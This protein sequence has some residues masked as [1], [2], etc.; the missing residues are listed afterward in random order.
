MTDTDRIDQ[1]RAAIAQVERTR[2]DYRLAVLR[3]KLLTKAAQGTVTVP[4][5]TS[6]QAVEL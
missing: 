1:L 6:S 5:A 3:L 2:Q 4:D